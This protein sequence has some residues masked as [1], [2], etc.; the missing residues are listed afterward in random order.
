MFSHIKKSLRSYRFLCLLWA[1]IF[2]GG[3]AG[4]ILGP[5]AL[6]LKPLGDIFLNLMFTFVV[7]LVFFSIASAL[8]GLGD[9]KKLWKI[10]AT[11]L[12]VFIFTGFLA[13]F[14]MLVIVKCFPPAQA[15]FLAL[16]GST[17]APSLTLAEQLVGIFTVSDFI[18]VFSRE[19]MLALILFA[20]LVGVATASLGET[21][22]AFSHFLQVGTA[23]FMKAVSYVMYYAPIGFFAYFA[24]LVG[25]LGPQLMTT[26][27]RATL[28]YYLAAL[29]YF[30]V[31]FSFYAYLADKKAGVKSFWTHISL[32]ALTALAT[33]SSAASI[34][35]NLQAAQKMKVSAE[36]AEMVIPIGSLIHKEGS[37]LGGLV[38]IAFLFGI[39]HLDFSGAAVLG[40]ALFMG[41][42]VGTV[43]GAIPSGGLVGE[44]L[45]LSVYGFPAQSLIVIAAISLLIDPP[46]TLLNVTG[47]SVSSM[48]VARLIEGKKWARLAK[49]IPVF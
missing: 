1:S 19:N 38:K 9:L 6:M 21:G 42:L 44:M 37:I 49:A 43:M 27:Y 40:M 34:P 17:H 2:L 39:F 26:Y 28:I 45:I 30:V 35:A 31:G 15:V 3:L 33:C 47:N 5:Q 23:I 25:E 12:G 29:V 16:T 10:T 36:L 41:V 24:V 14:Y 13:A 11:M 8:A 22:K 32:P 7:P 4:Y 20:G 48:L 18:K 46:A